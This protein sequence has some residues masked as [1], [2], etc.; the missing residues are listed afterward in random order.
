MCSVPRRHTSLL[1]LIWETLLG[2][3][4][5]ILRMKGHL[6]RLGAFRVVWL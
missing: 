3:R 5:L 4:S 1:T 6:M 2:K